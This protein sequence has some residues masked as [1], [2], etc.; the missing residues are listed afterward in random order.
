MSPHLVAFR[1]AGRDIALEPT[2]P[3][4][5]PNP[6]TGHGMPRQR[7]RPADEPALVSWEQT[8]PQVD[9]LDWRKRAA[10]FGLG[11]GEAADDPDD[12]PDLFRAERLLANEEPEADAAQPVAD[13]EDA[14]FSPSVLFREAPEDG[15]TAK[16]ADPV[17]AYLVQ[18]GK[19]SLL[20]AKQEV[21]IGQQMEDARSELIAS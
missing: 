18:I 12:E 7:S 15:I 11:P 17:R 6:A 5:G 19:T 2:V 8:Q 14:E 20:T 16:E 1:V 3:T 4:D 13:E 21:E 9:V 10:N